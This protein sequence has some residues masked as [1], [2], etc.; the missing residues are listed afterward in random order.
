MLQ[1]D[2]SGEKAQN[3]DGQGPGDYRFTKENCCNWSRNQKQNRQRYRG[4]YIEPENHA[5]LV[6]GDRPLSEEGV[7]YTKV[8]EHL[9]EDEDNLGHRRQSVLGWRNQ[10]SDGHGREKCDDENG[11][12]AGK[13]LSL[14]ARGSTSCLTYVHVESPP[15]VTDRRVGYQSPPQRAGSRTWTGLVVSATV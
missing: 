11:Q 10:S 12:S 3:G 9:R 4:G 2:P 13:E 7:R 6:L 1:R 14:A 5:D 8:A 15:N